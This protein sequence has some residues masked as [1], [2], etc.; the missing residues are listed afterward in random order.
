MT[1]T[2]TTRRL[3]LKAQTIGAAAAIVSAV[4]LPQLLHAIGA[5]TGLGSALGEILLPM[6]FPIILAGLLAG[7]YAAMTAGVLSPLLSFALTGMP[8]P[9]MLPFMMLELAVYGL[10]AGLLRTVSL[11]DTAKVLIVQLCGRI[12]RAGAILV[13]FYGFGGSVQPAVILTSIR[14]GLIGIALQLILIPVILACL[15]RADRASS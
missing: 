4:V 14:M 3:S 15:R 9:A 5:S 6:H 1:T 8:A 13:V 10:C 12:I 2:A 11:P 7:P